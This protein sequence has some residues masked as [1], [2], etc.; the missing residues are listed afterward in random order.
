[1]IIKQ[2]ERPTWK[3]FDGTK[4]NFGG[5]TVMIHW[6]LVPMPVAR[7]KKKKTAL[8]RAAN[9]LKSLAR[10]MENQADKI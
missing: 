10:E 6:S 2:P 8:K 4:G 1:M 7:A 3:I 5:C 9:R